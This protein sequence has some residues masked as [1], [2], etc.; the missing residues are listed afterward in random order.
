LVIGYGNTLR[1]D[2]GVGYRIAA[3]IAQW[4]L[5]GVR[6]LP[7]HQLTLD[8]A[9]TIAQS[10]V[11][12]FIDAYHSEAAVDP[13]RRENPPTSQEP[14]LSLVPIVPQ[15]TLTFTGHHLTPSA[16]LGCSQLLYNATPE[17]YQLLI[18]AIDLGWG[19]TF[20]AVTATAYQTAL[21]KLPLWLNALPNV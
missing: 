13:A 3:T 16:L 9:A 18:P 15:S 14:E 6:S 12:I 11:V 19:E 20:S 5:E 4:S 21:E 2:D 1:Q 7:V 10:S 8:L 17:A